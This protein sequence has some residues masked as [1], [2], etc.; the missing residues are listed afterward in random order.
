MARKHL[1]IFFA[2][3]SCRSIAGK[4]ARMNGDRV[5]AM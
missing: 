2:K 3:P 5:H 4:A 1:A